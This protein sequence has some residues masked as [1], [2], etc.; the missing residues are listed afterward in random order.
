MKKKI[1]FSMYNLDIGG[2][3]TALINILKN[4]DYDKYDVTLFLE[5]KEGIFINE[6]PN[7]VKIINYNLCDSKNIIFRK[8]KNRLNLIYNIIKFYKKYDCGICYASHRKVGSTLIPFISKKNILW[9]HGNYWD[10]DKTFDKF[11]IDF[12]VNKYNNIV[13]VSN[14]LKDKFLKYNNNINKTNLYSLNNI[15]DYENMLNLAE[16]EKII[17]NKITFLNVGRH[18]EEEKNLSMLINVVKKLVS[19]KYDFEVLLIGDGPDHEYYKKIV[20]DLNLSNTIKFLGKKKNPFPYYKIADALLLTSKKEGNPVVFLESKV[21]NVPIITTDVS[22]AKN[23]INGKYGIVSKND[24]DSYYEVLKKF[25][26]SGFIIQ[27][28]F[29]YKNYNENILKNIYEIIDN[30]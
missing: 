20:K 2:I 16:E 23:D 26:D 19:D 18:T 15:I 12:N 14:A 9:I 21:F 10:N 13:F 24:F 11:L 30:G 17:K 6:I 3:E 28:K 22:D 1:I 25:L 29:D 4:F 27:T 5:K 7:Q 8:I